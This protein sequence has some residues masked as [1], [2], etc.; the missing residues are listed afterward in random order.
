MERLPS[1]RPSGSV[2]PQYLLKKR[3]R[4]SETPAAPPA[5]SSAPLPQE[6]APLITSDATNDN[7]EGEDCTQQ[8]QQQQQQHQPPT[9]KL[10]KAEETFLANR[11]FTSGELE[12]LSLKITTAMIDIQKQI[13]RGEETYYEDT[14]AHGSLFR[15]W[16]AFVDSKE[17]MITP[18]G[19]SAAQPAT[20]RRVPSDMRWFS[21]S[22]RSVTRNARPSLIKA[23]Q[24]IHGSRP[25]SATQLLQPDGTLSGS[26]SRSETNTPIPTVASNISVATT[27]AITNVKGGNAAIA[28][29]VVEEKW[30]KSSQPVAS[31]GST[32]SNVQTTM[33]TQ[34]TPAAVASS[35]AEKKDA[36]ASNPSDAS[37]TK[38][39]SEEAGVTMSADRPAMASNK[40]D[41][42]TE[43]K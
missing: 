9:K 12:D 31:S 15:G 7:K 20:T 16:D 2:L 28:K 40:T 3:I 24:H 41:P 29:P 18:G 1:T 5:V 39:K 6:T 37:G 38:R 42:S 22:C 43:S 33:A 14:Y 10:T 27:A 23:F 21:G 11:A 25:A 19:S 26:V 36:A 34:G 32:Q 30:V 8:E 4:T 17:S 13:Y 35:K